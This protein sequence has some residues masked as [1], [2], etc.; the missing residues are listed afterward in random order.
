MR[1][2]RGLRSLLIILSQ[3]LGLVFHATANAHPVPYMGAVG[4]MEWNQPFMT[5]DWITYSFRPDMAVVARHMRFDT[6]EG[7]ARFYAPQFDIIL[8]RWNGAGHQANI[9]GYGAFGIM[10]FDG[11][12]QG[13]GLAGIDMDAE[14]RKLFVSAKYEKM[15]GNLGPD[16]YRAEVRLGVAPYEAEFNEV[17]SWFMIQYQYNPTLVTKYAITPLARVFYKSFLFEAGVSTDSEWMLNFMF[18]L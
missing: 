14:S 10:S 2:I 3:A 8:K 12:N 15:W 13:A 6:P 5:D 9:Y 7:R 1:S 17:A 4:V 16:F 11:Q 18:H